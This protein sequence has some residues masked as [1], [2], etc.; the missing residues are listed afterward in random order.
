MM[1]SRA[2]FT[3]FFFLKSSLLLLDPCLVLLVLL[4]FVD[5]VAR[6]HDF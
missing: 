4:V 5:E 1:R 3:I 6:G 2:A